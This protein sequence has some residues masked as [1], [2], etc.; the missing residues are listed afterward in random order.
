[1]RRIRSIRGAGSRS[2]RK[3]EALWMLRERGVRITSVVDVGVLHG[4]PELV[5]VFPDLPHILFE[6]VS[7]CAYRIEKVYR[8]VDYTLVQ[9]AVGERDGHCNLRIRGEAGALTSSAHVERAPGEDV[10]SVE[11]I[12]LDTFCAQAGPIDDGLLKIDTDGH[13]EAVLQ[14][15]GEFVGKCSVVII[16]ST[17][18]N[19]NKILD[20]MFGMGFLIFDI[21]EPCYY[22]GALWQVDIIFIRK[23]IMEMNFDT[24]SDK[25][26]DFSKYEIFK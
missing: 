8:N 21:V 7:E 13:E 11:L 10:R 6:P 20:L 12:S 2:P 5:D 23:D 22:D 14:G 24:I 1:M 25:G 9:K 17:N 15:G 18:A 26:V 3:L 4:T 16:E 19:M